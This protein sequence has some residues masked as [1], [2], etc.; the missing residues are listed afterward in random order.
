M[1]GDWQRQ[2]SFVQI[3]ELETG[4]ELADINT[5][6]TYRM[7]QGHSSNCFREYSFLQISTSLSEV[8]QPCYRTLSLLVVVSGRLGTCKLDAIIQLSFAAG[9]DH[10]TDF[11]ACASH[12]PVLELT[13]RHGSVQAH[14]FDIS[15]IMLDA[16]PVSVSAA[17][18]FR[19][20]LANDNKAAGQDLAQGF[21]SKPVSKL[22][23]ESSLLEPL[24]GL[25]ELEKS[26]G[27]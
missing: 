13:A 6:H 25:R 1:E 27:A 23:C 19:V 15:G 11:V 4:L 16:V 10:S 20:Q 5:R 7:C 22:R 2:Q 8:G 14:F 21:G 17:V 3:R 18:L 26:V 9:F 12:T 24:S